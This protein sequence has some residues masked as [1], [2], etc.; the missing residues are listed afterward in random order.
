MV[1]TSGG[2]GLQELKEKIAQIG[3]K[4]VRIGFPENATYPD[5]TKVAYVATIQEFGA[6][7]IPPRPFLRPTIA[8]QREAWKKTLQRGYKAV[9]SDSISLEAMLAQFGMMAAGQVKA[10][11][12][13]IHTPPLSIT[14]LL[15][16]KAKKQ[17]GFKA[18][19]KAVGEAKR[20]AAF[21]GPRPQGDSTMD[22][23]G[24]SEKPLVDTGYLISQVG[25]EVIDV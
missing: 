14:T 21:E 22:V 3:K 2:K 25:H 10:K 6:G 19:G 24:V 9:V 11:I 5:G 13:S 12:A 4:Q 20:Q 8:E 16:R 15:M 17:E 1:Q 7:P 18:G 23:S